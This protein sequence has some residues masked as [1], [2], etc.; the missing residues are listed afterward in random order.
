MALTTT[1]LTA[2]A[3]TAIALTAIALTAMALTSKHV[4]EIDSHRPRHEKP[5][6]IVVVV[7]VVAHGLPDATFDRRFDRRFDKTLTVLFAALASP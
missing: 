7:D 4:L 2:I 3:L 5:T 6:S 1:A